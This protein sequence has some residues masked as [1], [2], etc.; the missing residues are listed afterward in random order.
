MTHEAHAADVARASLLGFSSRLR[1]LLGTLESA[2]LV[3]AIGGAHAR[4]RRAPALRL[5]RAPLRRGARRAR[6]RD[7]RAAQRAH[8]REP[9]G[10]PPRRARLFAE[11][12]AL[13][14][15]ARRRQRTR[16]RARG[17]RS[18]D[19]RAP[20]PCSRRTP[21]AGIF[22]PIRI[23]ES[24]IGGAALLFD[25]RVSTD[26]PLEMAERLAEVLA[27]TVESFRTE[28]M[29]FSLFARALPDLLDENAP[30][31][32]REALSRYVHALRLAPDLQ[33]PAR[34]R[35]RGRAGSAIAGA[36]EAA[37]CA[38]V[39]GA[40][41]RVCRGMSGIASDGRGM[42]VVTDAPTSGP[43]SGPRRS[44]SRSSTR[45]SIRR[46]RGSRTPAS[47]R[48]AWRR[49][50]EGFAVR[51]AEPVDLRGTGRRA[52][53][54]STS[55]RPSSRSRACACSRPRAAARATGCSAAIRWCVRERFDVVNLS[56]GIDVPTGAPLRPTD[57]KSIVELYEIAD[58]RL[59]GG[60]RARRLGAERVR[61]PHV[62]GPVQIAHRRRPRGVR[63]SRVLRTEITVDCEILAPGTDVLAPALGGGERRWTGTSFA[64]PARR[65]ARGA[66][67]AAQ[68]GRD[69]D[70][71]GHQ[72]RAARARGQAA[73]ARRRAA[74][75]HDDRGGRGR[76][77]KPARRRA[78]LIR[79]LDP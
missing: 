13:R 4:A 61:V 76:P 23:G 28:Q 22:V 14:V 9:G 46:T 54:S 20:R 30:T 2:A 8:R 67:C 69:F 45:A 21:R 29:I 7:A 63:R 47:A 75:G 11:R 50:G 59:H 36:A 18:D 38:D 40:H 48:C 79:P 68:S 24:T 39:L 57:Y 72:G 64:V 35:A 56:L 33:G 70:H 26:K 66:R 15:P 37:L 53:G 73:R 52:R 44:A 32:L 42:T 49:Q 19:R 5:P 71:P 3:G 78:R 58:A 34:A 31:S 25:E 12:D 77:A 10:L 6:G 27:L 1:D 65:R 60:R 74:R 41:R 16:G 55:S 51:P 43:Q 17:R 62:P